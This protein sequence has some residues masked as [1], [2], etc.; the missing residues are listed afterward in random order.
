MWK[1]FSRAKNR[2][3]DRIEYMNT[4]ELKKLGELARV[5]MSD[6]ELE[7]IARDFDGILEYIKQLDSVD[8]TDAKPWY[9][10]VTN[11]GRADVPESASPE[12]H[13]LVIQNLPDTVDGFLKVPKIL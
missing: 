2:F 5:G 12:S 3:Y 1:T 6:H 7:T 4:A 13:D 8:T 10:T 11:I 9:G